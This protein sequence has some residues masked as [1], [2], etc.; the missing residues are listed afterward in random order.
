M[1]A[2]L[3]YLVLPRGRVHGVVPVRVP[4][5]VHGVGKWEVA[6]LTLLMDVCVCVCE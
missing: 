5:R 2:I 4:V 6:P 3:S 1:H